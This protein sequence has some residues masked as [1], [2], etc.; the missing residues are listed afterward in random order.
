MDD[1]MRQNRIMTAT[2]TNK[3]GVIESFER[4]IS[5]A[6]VDDTNLEGGKITYND[7]IDIEQNWD[8]IV[9]SDRSSSSDDVLLYIYPSSSHFFSFSLSP[10]MQLMLQMSL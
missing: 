7:D 4:S 10:L 3:L 9:S 2:L 1:A 6:G 5:H 8:L